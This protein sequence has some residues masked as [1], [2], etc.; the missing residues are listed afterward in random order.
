MITIDPQSPVPI[1]DQIKAGIKGLVTKGLLRPGDAL[2]S[3]RALAEQLLVNPNTIAR[4]YRELSFEGLLESKRG[5]GNYIAE[6][7]MRNARDGLEEV[8]EGLLGALRQA[9]AGGLGWKEIAA[10]VEKSKGDES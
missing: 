1:N 2:P 4:A 7:A 5:E 10:L 6:S 8:R 9:R 3:I